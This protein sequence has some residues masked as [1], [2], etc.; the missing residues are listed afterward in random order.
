VTADFTL[1]ISKEIKGRIGHC[2][3]S[4]R[5]AIRRRLL[6]IAATAG[7]SRN[8]AKVHAHEGPSPSFYVYEGHRVFYRI[9]S[10]SR[11]VVVRSVELL[12]ID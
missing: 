1:D 10:A 4:V 5:E 12:P 6:E 3:A 7:R 2:R 9:D 8:G 11:R